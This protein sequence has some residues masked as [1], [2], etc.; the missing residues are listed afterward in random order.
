MFRRCE[1][2]SFVFVRVKLHRKESSLQE[3]CETL[4][5]S[6]VT[7]TAP[8]WFRCDKVVDL[9][10]I[11]GGTEYKSVLCGAIAHCPG[12]LGYC[13]TT[14]PV[15]F[16]ARHVGLDLMTVPLVVHHKERVQHVSGGKQQSLW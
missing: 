1:C 12:C 8:G 7:T 6:W 3:K 13:L 11:K 10:P 2:R 9:K 4:G 5:H 15:V 14:H 16:C